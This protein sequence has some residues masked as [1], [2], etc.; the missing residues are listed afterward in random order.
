V[1]VKDGG[2]GLVEFF[3]EVS[4]VCN[5]FGYLVKLV[6]LP[7]YLLS[8][9]L[10]S[11]GII[12]SCDDVMKIYSNQRKGCFSSC[13]SDGFFGLVMSMCNCKTIYSIKADGWTHRENHECKRRDF[14]GR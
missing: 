11:D 4:I 1:T 7:S 5:P 2:G 8:S 3:S 14:R 10:K 13:P 9:L 12:S 6:G